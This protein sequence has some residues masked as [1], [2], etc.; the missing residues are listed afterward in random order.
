M[1]E[2][3]KKKTKKTKQKK[4]KKNTTWSMGPTTRKSSS[5]YSSFQG[6]IVKHRRV[7]GFKM[8]IPVSA[9]NATGHSE[10]TPTKEGQGR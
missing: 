1:A 4:K 6:S 2:K 10:G 3:K 5:L 7:A 8:A 9:A